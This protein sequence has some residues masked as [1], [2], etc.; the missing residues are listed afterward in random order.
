MFV[1]HEKTCRIIFYL[2]S[3]FGITQ[4]QSLQINSL[5]RFEMIFSELYQ[6]S[7]WCIL[8]GSK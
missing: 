7:K 6:Y 4:K 2:N 8:E 3:F 5:E 1:I